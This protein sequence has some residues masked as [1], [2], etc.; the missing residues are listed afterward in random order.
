VKAYR[1]HL[2]VICVLAV[3]LL[4]GTHR[5]LEN[6]LTDMRFSVL[7]RPATGQLVVVAIDPPSI[8]AIGVWPWPRSI[9]AKLIE[10]L[11]HAGASD[12]VFDVDFSSPSNPSADKT[13]EQALRQA[14]GS[15][16]L[17]SFQQTVGD[18]GRGTSIH[19][20]RPLP[21]FA[22]HAWSAM[23]NVTVDSDGLVRRYMLGERID[24]T[25]VPSVGALLAGVYQ[26]QVGDFL[27]DYGIRPG[28]VSTI[29]YIDVL[30][31]NPDAVAKLNGKK[32]LVGA[33]ALELGD[34]FNVPRGQV[35]PG[36]LLQALAAESILQGRTLRPTS[37]LIS[38]AE[39][40]IIVVVMMLVWRRS[41]GTRLAILAGLA[42]TVEA[43]AIALQA[44]APISI[45]TSL[46]HITIAAYLAA[47]ALDEIDFRGLLGKVAEDRFQRI[48]MSLGDGL[49]CT[50]QKGIVTFWNPGAEAI[51]GYQPTDIVGRPFDSVC[52][53]PDDPGSPQS[54][55][56]LSQ[57]SLRIP[58][59]IVMEIEGR[60]ANGE[61]FPLEAC[62]SA[63][64]GTEGFQYGAVFRDISDRKREAERIRY[65]AQH[66]TLTGL[67]NRNTLHE[68]LD[69]LIEAA[70]HQATQI[71][72]LVLDL[73][74]FKE[75]ND[76]LG[77]T[78]G[79][80]VLCAVALHLE[81]LTQDAGL[82]A[83]LSG[84]E[85]AIVLSGDD[86][87]AKARALSERITSAMSKSVIAVSGRWLRVRCSIG[88]AIFP[89]DCAMG[90]ELL[91]NADLA[92]YR[93]KAAGRGGYA[94]FDRSIRDELESQ[95][96]SKNELE[97]AVKQGEFE[98]FYQPQVSLTDGKLLGAEA[99]IRWRHPERGLVSPAEF[100]PIVN[101]TS[102]SDTVG[103]WV[104]QTACR[105]GRRWQ[106]QGREMVIGVNLSPSQLQSDDFPETIAAILQE[107]GLSPHLLEL[108]V[109]ENILLE[110]DDRVI[111]I[112]Q[113]IRSLGVRIALDDFGTGYASL[114]Y[115]KKFPIDRLKIDRSF[116]MELGT[117]SDD[118]AIVSST[119]NLAK[120][121]GLAVIAEG[122]EE[123]STVDLLLGMGCEVGQGYHF[124]PPVSAER[125]EQ[126]FFAERTSPTFRAASAA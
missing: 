103:L 44:V 91:S 110:D 111:D 81:E 89:D 122:I 61:L 92:L 57:A 10:K 27:I 40:A 121:L 58:G 100:M 106:E 84:D 36:V 20:N 16:V 75:I 115:L 1:A 90:E 15:V 96:R 9:H 54:L 17:P 51:F 117:N 123:R 24:E 8:E 4:T 87:A 42:I 12:I 13:F 97:R 79:D 59:G 98:L 55:L 21:L 66:D 67:A 113:R 125:F 78:Y 37:F 85:F 65:L 25:F 31:G 41:A 94:F 7:T 102:L 74:K 77:H 120:L 14:G 32:V 114:S 22:E 19:V 6:A 71:A 124:S 28:T 26:R 101:T 46:L 119:V 93:A 70:K 29:S 88:V 64:Q 126:S 83:R 112:F 50:D 63:W 82:L 38:L 108:E 68:H 73:D 30:N 18:R 53:W 39:I 33:T 105:Q 62:F 47:V 23:V 35:V 11:E 43:S 118:V 76:S 5:V 104:I 95:L 60:R 109:T 56:A 99:L 3:A 2:F 48:T 107:T 45:D 86:V 72:L 49:M 52:K 69:Q 116:V 34:R 80:R